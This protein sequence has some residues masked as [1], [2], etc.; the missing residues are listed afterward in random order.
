MSLKDNITMVKEELNSEEKFFEKAVMT[1]KFIKKYKRVMI[2]SVAVVA[3]VVGANLLYDANEKSKA[4][5]ANAALSKLQADANN[6]TA[7][8]ELKAVSPNLYDVW[9]FSQAVAKKDLEALNGL[10]NSK[11]L[12]VGDLAKYEA[13]Q[14]AASL[15][16]YA[17]KQDAIFR[18]LALVQSAVLLFSENKIDEAKEKLSKVSKDSSLNKMVSALMHYGIK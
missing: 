14:T 15:D 13:A 12:V 18:D 6:A 10:K 9:I 16:E 17:S 3:F 7:L 8:N 1:E 4:A 2:A 11:A 5:A